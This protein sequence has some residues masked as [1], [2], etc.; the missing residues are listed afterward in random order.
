MALFPF[1]VFEDAA[2]AERRGA[3]VDVRQAVSAT[4]A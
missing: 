2:K 4:I 3:Q 1:V